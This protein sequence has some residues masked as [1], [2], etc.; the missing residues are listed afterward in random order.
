MTPKSSPSIALLLLLLSLLLSLSANTAAAQTTTTTTSLSNITAAEQQI[1]GLAEIADLDLPTCGVCTYL[2][3]LSCIML[4]YFLMMIIQGLCF[5]QE[6]PDY[7]CPL[8]NPS[9][10]CSNANLTTA[11]SACT[12]ANCT[13]P[14][15]LCTC[16]FFFFLFGVI[17]EY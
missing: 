5:L 10:M 15:Q 1:Q 17:D 7:D 3:Y 14:E 6:F 13:I 2:T 8:N 9:C 16:F 4:F 12:Y 11:I